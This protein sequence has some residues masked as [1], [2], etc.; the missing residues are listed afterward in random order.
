MSLPPLPPRCTSWIA[1]S[2]ETGKAYFETW[3]PA[4][5]E[6]AQLQGYDVVSALQHLQELNAK[7]KA[8]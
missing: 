1:R 8:D 2:P 6:H 7:L 3:N 5:A 4:I